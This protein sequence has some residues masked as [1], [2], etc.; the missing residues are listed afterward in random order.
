MVEAIKPKEIALAK[1]RYFP[2]FVLQAFNELIA[3]KFTNGSA[4]VKQC[5]V[6]A[7][8]VK[9]A[10]SEEVSRNTIFANGWLNVE[11]IYREAGWKVVYDKPGYNESYDANFKFSEKR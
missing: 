9:L 7:R 4:T 1:S 5:D 11:E 3:E 10:A 8:M 2:D 6:I